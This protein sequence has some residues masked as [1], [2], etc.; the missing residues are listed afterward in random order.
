MGAVTERRGQDA[1]RKGLAVAVAGLMAAPVLVMGSPAH[2]EPCTA[3]AEVCDVV[4]H[5]YYRA[6]ETVQGVYCEVRPPCR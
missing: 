5:Y 1:W 2:A 3:P 4:N 6:Y